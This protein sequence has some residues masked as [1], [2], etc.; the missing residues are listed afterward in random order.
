MA[1]PCECA[2]G[3]L[4]GLVL[5]IASALD[6]YGGGGGV[7]GDGVD[8]FCGGEG[9]DLFVQLVRFF[10]KAVAM[11][12]IC[13]GEGCGGFIGIDAWVADEEQVVSNAIAAVGGD[14]RQLLGVR[15]DFDVERCGLIFAE[16]DALKDDF[17][18]EHDG[19][20]GPGLGGTG[21]GSE[22]DGSVE[23][24]RLFS[25]RSAEGIEIEG[26]AAIRVHAEEGVSGRGV[27]DSVEG[28]GALRVEGP[29]SE[30]VPCVAAGGREAFRF[31]SWGQI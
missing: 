31:G 13:W 9:A 30:G 24:E 4:F 14:E 22:A 19:E 16:A 15:G 2:W 26:G 20:V 28:G 8:F 11:G 5:G 17:F 3:Y 1:D 12:K 29:V 23:T 18:I 6:F 21:I 25:E 10:A 27:V 7:G